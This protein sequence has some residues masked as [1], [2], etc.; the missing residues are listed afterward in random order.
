MNI[1]IDRP[2]FEQLLK[3]TIYSTIIGSKMY[4][5]DDE[6]SDTDILHIFYPSV[7]MTRSFIHTHHQL[8]FKQD[9]IDYI[10]V[11]IFN[12]I[13]N[14]LSGDSTINYEVMQNIPFFDASIFRN[15]KIIRSYLGLARRDIK[16]IS[17]L[18]GRDKHKKAGHIMRSYNFAKSILDDNFNSKI[19]GSLLDEY[20]SI[21]NMSNKEL[22]DYVMVYRDKIS[23]LRITLNDIFETDTNNIPRYCS[24]NNQKRIDRQLNNILITHKR[25]QQPYIDI[26]M[27]YDMNENGI[28]YD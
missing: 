5:T 3:S 7:N 22:H 28:N 21:K 8:Q 25:L 4:G 23:E 20:R 6:Y 15:Y 18:N 27:I 14:C 19:T 11:D 1:H 13:R 17:K 26:T 24:I 2:I 16:E 10:F 12:Y 9:N